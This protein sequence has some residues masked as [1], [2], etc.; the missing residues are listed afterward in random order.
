VTTRAA[1]PKPRLVLRPAPGV[2]LPRRPDRFQALT[3]GGPRYTLVDTD[4]LDQSVAAL[5]EALARYGG[6][7][8]ETAP[9]AL[10]TP[11]PVTVTGLELTLP[12]GERVFTA[13]SSAGVRAAVCGTFSAVLLGPAAEFAVSRRLL[14]PVEL[15]GL[16]FIATSAALW[17]AVHA[18]R[19]R[20]RPLR[21][22]VGPAG[23]AVREPAGE[24]LLVLWQQIAAVT[25]GPLPHGSDPA[26][27]LMV[28][29]LPGASL[30]RPRTHLVDGHQAY[31]LVRLD[32][33]PDGENTVPPAVRSYVGE[34]FSAHPRP[35]A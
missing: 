12:G 28:W 32:R 35:T 26:P 1:P 18:G 4:D 14:N 19:R 23:L 16:W 27:W 21:L 8:F 10:R 6:A 3:G 29:P 31:A 7:R 11:T 25:V 17:G 5:A 34:R 13:A 20:R 33:L 22:R 24:D 30:A 9:R 15:I 2:V